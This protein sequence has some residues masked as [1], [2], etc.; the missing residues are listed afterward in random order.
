M[1][2]PSNAPIPMASVRQDRPVHVDREPN[3]M[4][5]REHYEPTK[6]DAPDVSGDGRTI[7]IKPRRYVE[8]QLDGA[9]GPVHIEL[10][11]DQALAVGRALLDASTRLGA[12]R[13]F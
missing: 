6:V 7:V 4:N 12:A 1:T 13:P 8:L 11:V 9:G 5:S 10:S 3:G 2:D